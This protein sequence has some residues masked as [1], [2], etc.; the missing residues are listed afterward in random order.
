MPEQPTLSP[1]GKKL[2]DVVRDVLRTKHYSYRTEQT[3]VDWIKRYIFFHQK[4]HPKDMG[5]EEIQA[6]ITHL[7]TDRKVA[8]STQNQALSAILFLYRIVLQKEI[9]LPPE[10]VRASRPKILPTV[11][12]HAE[13]MAVINKMRGTSRLMTKILYGSGLR[14]M[15]CLRLRVKDIDFGNHQIIVRAGN[16]EDDRFTILPDSIV[17]ELHLYLRKC[18]QT[19]LQDVKALHD[20]DLREGCGEAALPYALNV[21]YPNAGREWAWQFV[22]PA[23]QRSLDPL[24]GVIRRHH[25]DEIVLQKAVRQAAKLAKIDK[26]V[27]PHT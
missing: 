25:L 26:S 27:S 7:A 19:H 6:F 10:L 4:R 3:Y 18:R 24:S 15:E 11:L 12:T 14:L 20:K 2:L 1:Q 23:S 9:N 21:K 22:F 5:A 13:A 17:S 16:G 8:A